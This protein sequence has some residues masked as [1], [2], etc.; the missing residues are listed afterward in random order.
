MNKKEVIKKIGKENWKNFQKFMTGQ[1]VGFDKGITDYY[2]WDVDVFVSALG[3]K[4][5]NGDKIG[6]NN[7]RRTL[8]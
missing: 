3:R 2:E 4:N 5:K 6:N 7:T 1:T 8:D